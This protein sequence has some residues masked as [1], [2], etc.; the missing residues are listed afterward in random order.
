MSSK[1]RKFV[2]YKNQSD[3]E[4]VTKIE[5]LELILIKRHINV[6]KTDD[7]NTFSFPD[8]PHG[9]DD[10]LH[11]Q[12]HRILDIVYDSDE[13]TGYYDNCI[14]C[15]KPYVKAMDEID[16]LLHKKIVAKYKE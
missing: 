3:E 7:T 2:D 10:R 13:D 5:A 11:T 1:M 15:R 16:A 4:L 6:E 14:E 12:M 9:L 8:L